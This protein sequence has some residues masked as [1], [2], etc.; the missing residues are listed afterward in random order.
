MIPLINFPKLESPLVRKYLDVPFVKGLHS[1]RYT[2]KLYLAT[3]E[4]V[5]DWIYDDGVRAVDK[6]DGT[7]ICVH[8]RD[9]DIVCV[10]NREQR[11]GNVFRIDVTKYQAVM[12]EGIANTL[13]RGWLKHPDKLIMPWQ[14]DDRCEHCGRGGEDN[15]YQV[16]GELI[17]PSINS[18]RH[19]IQHH[20]FV[21]FAYLVQHCAWRSWFEGKPGYELLP[22]K[23]FEALKKWIGNRTSLFN[24]RMKFPEIPAEGVVFHH[25]DGRMCKLRHDMFHYEGKV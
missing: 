9:G 6:V 14:K 1:H 18:N 12:A 3:S 10:D 15:A 23:R 2:K 20:L 5:H 24:E 4:M 21:P 25:P 8:I 7:S 17:G 16:Y 22:T 13:R 11:L 19:H